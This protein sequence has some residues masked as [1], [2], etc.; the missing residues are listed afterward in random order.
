MNWELV[1]FKT[2]GCPEVKETP[3]TRRT[4]VNNCNLN[5]SWL[6]RKIVFLC[7]RITIHS[8]SSHYSNHK[9]YNWKRMR[10]WM[11][12]GQRS[13]ESPFGPMP[14][15]W[16]GTWLFRDSQSSLVF[17]CIHFIGVHFG[18][19]SRESLMAQRPSW[20]LGH[21]SSESY[22]ASHPFWHSPNPVNVVSLDPPVLTPKS[23]NW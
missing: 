17:S 5:Q 4:Q 22:R 9:V 7:R 15:I 6:K 2:R 1:S 16:L 12:L 19:H 3:T 18:L 20:P 10:M 13:I 11:W 23:K 14:V 8:G 21:F